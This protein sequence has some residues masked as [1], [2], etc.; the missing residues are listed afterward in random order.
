M[1]NQSSLPS[2]KLYILILLLP[3]TN[4]CCILHK[5]CQERSEGPLFVGVHFSRTL[6]PETL[7]R[8]HS[9]LRQYKGGCGRRRCRSGLATVGSSRLFVYVYVYVRVYGCRRMH[10]G[11][12]LYTCITVYAFV[13][14]R[15]CVY[16][17]IDMYVL[18]SCSFFFFPLFDVF[19]SSTNLRTYI[20][21]S[22][23]VLPLSLI[24]SSYRSV[25]VLFT[26][27]NSFVFYPFLDKYC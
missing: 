13:W 23:T 18:F 20:S 2:P 22:F 4:S 9:R 8:A 1:E 3:P 5:P 24:S 19:I 14:T 17:C 11:F 15:T 16:I 10:I 21:L 26:F 7:A 25:C 12:C 6:N 27:A